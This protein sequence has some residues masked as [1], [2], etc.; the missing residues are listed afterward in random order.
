MAKSERV[1][2]QYR[3]AFT[4]DGYDSVR[5]LYK[6]HSKAEDARD[7]AGLLATLTRDCVYELVQ[8]GQRWE[9]HTGAATF[10]AELLGAFPDVVFDLENIVIGPQGVYEEAQVT[11]TWK[12]DWLGQPATGEAMEWRVSILFPYDPAA[13]LFTGE[14]VY[15]DDVTRFVRG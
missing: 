4:T 6:A 9:G 7:I 1:L 10:Y 12:Q 11:G 5:E 14:R 2:E 8:T 3:R 13:G 15:V